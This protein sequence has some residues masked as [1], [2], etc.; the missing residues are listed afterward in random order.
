MEW[1]D[2]WVCGCCKN[3]FLVVEDKSGVL[4]PE[5]HAK[6]MY[7]PYCGGEEVIMY[8]DMEG[9][10]AEFVVEDEDGNELDKMNFESIDEL[11]DWLKGDDEDEDESF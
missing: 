2:T 6:P 10:D 1:L 9:A 4:M 11:M 3:K 8:E 5:I 7:C